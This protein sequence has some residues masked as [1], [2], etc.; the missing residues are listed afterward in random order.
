[1]VTTMTMTIV[2]IHRRHFPRKSNTRPRAT[3]AGA[4][5]LPS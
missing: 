2:V 5:T 3:R 1:M 4:F